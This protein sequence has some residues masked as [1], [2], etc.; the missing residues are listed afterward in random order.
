M[1]VHKKGSKSDPSNYRLILQLSIVN[2]TLD[3]N[4]NHNRSQEEE[5]E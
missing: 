5:E 4:H 3:T 1:S 2:K